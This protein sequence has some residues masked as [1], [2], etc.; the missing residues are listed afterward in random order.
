MP[1]FYDPANND[2]TA[3]SAADREILNDIGAKCTELLMP[4]PGE[5][6]NRWLDKLNRQ[7]YIHVLSPDERNARV[8]AAAR[9]SGKP[10]VTRSGEPEAPATARPTTVDEYLKQRGETRQA[11]HDRVLHRFAQPGQARTIQETPR[12]LPDVARPISGK[13]V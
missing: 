8:I 11:A 10:V 9:R 13:V 4:E 3:L 6:F 2:F 12:S 7:G 5:E 1:S